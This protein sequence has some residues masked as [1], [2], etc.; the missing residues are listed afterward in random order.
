MP[1]HSHGQVRNQ[2]NELRKVGKIKAKAERRKR[3]LVFVRVKDPK[4]QSRVAVSFF[5]RKNRKAPSPTVDTN[6]KPMVLKQEVGSSTIEQTLKDILGEIRHLDQQPIHQIRIRL[7]TVQR[8]IF[9]L[10]EERNVP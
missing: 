9:N 7:G 6:G 3:S 5:Q 2:V 1:E 10:M 4:Q 8:W